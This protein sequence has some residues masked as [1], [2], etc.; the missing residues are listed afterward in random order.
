MSCR[1]RALEETSPALLGWNK[2]Q[3]SETE[4]S[5]QQQQWRLDSILRCQLFHKQRVPWIKRRL[6]TLQ[7]EFYSKSI[8]CYMFW[9][10]VLKNCQNS[11]I[12]S[13]INGIMEE[14]AKWK[15]PE[16]LVP[17]KCAFPG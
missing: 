11:H 5:L 8:K 4:A 7:E 13:L 3:I 15:S 10:D 6:G 12:D 1:Q 16:F 14:R 17:S 9:V 2:V